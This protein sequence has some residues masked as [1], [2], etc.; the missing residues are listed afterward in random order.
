MNRFDIALNR[1]PYDLVGEIPKWLDDCINNIQPDPAKDLKTWVELPE[2]KAVVI[3]HHNIG[4]ALRNSLG[5]W[6][7][8]KFLSK[9]FNKIGVYHP[10][11]MSGIILTS[12][13]ESTIINL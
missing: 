5:L 9:C 6:E 12:V 1:S 11:D 7:A 13:I 3:A 10:D 4:R 8:E 2:E